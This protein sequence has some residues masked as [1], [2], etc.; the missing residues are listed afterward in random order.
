MTLGNRKVVLLR[1][2][3]TFGAGLILSQNGEILTAE[4]DTLRF[5]Y[6]YL[7]VEGDG[8]NWVQI[9]DNNDILIYQIA[10]ND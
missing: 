8:R 1:P 4:G 10:Y 2:I 9:Y 7:L 3:S 6:D 5:G